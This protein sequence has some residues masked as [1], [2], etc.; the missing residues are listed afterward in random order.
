MLEEVFMKGNSSRRNFLAAGLGLPVAGLG[1]VSSPSLLSKLDSAA[2]APQSSGGIRYR[3]LGKTG[4]KVS[5]VGFGCMITSDPSVIERAA[6]LGINYFDTSRGYQGGNNERMVGAALKKKRKDVILSTKTDGRSKES[7]L[8]ELETSLKELGTDYVDIWYL[9]AIGR[10]GQITD[11]LLEAQQAAKKAGKTRFTGVSSHGG[12]PE[13]IQA[14]ID[15]GQMEVVLAA[16]NFTMEGKL[17]SALEAA[18]KAGLGV[19]AMKV[20]AGGFRRA[21]QGTSL[22]TIFERDGALLAAL[23]WVVKDPRVHTTVP[24]MTDMDQLD[25]NMTAMTA[26]FT[27]ADQKLL[28]SQL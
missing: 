14:L 20:M 11:G 4:L 5:T 13:V 28:V 19:V 23:K 8:A 21:R 16:Y 22:R 9:H 26:S 12:Q 15:G 6:D 10:S 1:A 24:S 7:A 3:T 27:D 25:Q 18:N 2:L 17:D